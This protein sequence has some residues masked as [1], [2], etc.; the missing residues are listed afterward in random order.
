[1]RPKQTM[2][3]HQ[4]LYCLFLP[5]EEQWSSPHLGTGEEEPDPL[6]ADLE[7]AA[8]PG[9]DVLD[10]ELS[11]ELHAGRHAPHAPGRRPLH[12]GLD[13]V[14][15]VTAL[16]CVIF[17]QLCLSS[18]ASPETQNLKSHYCQH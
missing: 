5:P 11:P 17:V 14:V 9:L 7:Q 12:G 18:I 8:L 15:E 3:D 6:H 10:R 1:M 13:A 16:G 2:M 4:Q